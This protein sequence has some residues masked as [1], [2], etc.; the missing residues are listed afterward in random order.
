MR[1]V[2]FII[3]CFL[4]LLPYIRGQK[5][6]NA[7][8]NGQVPSVTDETT[9][10]IF[11]E[12]ATYLDAALNS[13]N[14]FSSL[15]RKENYR[16]KI[17]SFNNPASTDIGFSLE[18]EIRLSLKPLLAKART[19]HPEKF[20]NILSGIVNSQGKLGY[21]QGP[22]VAVNPVFATI[23]SIVGTLTIQ[24]KKI[25][26]EDLDS[27]SNNIS[28]YFLLYQKLNDANL[29]F[30]REMAKLEGAL[31]E[32]QF[33]VRQYMIDIIMVLNKEVSGIHLDT[34]KNEDLYLQF[35]DKSSIIGSCNSNPGRIRYPI[36]GIKTAKEIAGTLQKLWEQYQ[37]VFISNFRQ[38]RSVLQESRSI[39]NNV[40]QKKVDNSLNELEKLFNESRSADQL[41]FRLKTLLERLRGLVSAEQ[42]S[43]I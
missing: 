24:E 34:L 5:T 12:T 43:G 40:D 16:Q 22:L 4:F 41:A 38:I 21:T 19:V 33:D 3:A 26:M 30:D 1:K 23:M 27:F 6:D 29:V 28:R 14:S 9:V 18:N 11:L 13:I 20:S 35:L 32:L 31:R 25:T 10:A 42:K 8:I 2:C 39:G 17:I 37:S 15:I 36:D 7:I